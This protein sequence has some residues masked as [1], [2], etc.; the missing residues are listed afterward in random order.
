ML[1]CEARRGVCRMCYGR[2]LATMDMVDM[3]EAVGI[4]AAQSIGEPGTQLT[5]RTFHI[6]GTSSRIA[7]EAERRARSDG[8]V[9]YTDG[10][11]WADV[12]VEYEDGTTDHPAVVLT[13]EDESASDES[14][15]GILV[16]D[17]KDPKRVLNRYPVPEGALLAVKEGDLVTKGDN[18]RRATILYTWDPYNDP[19]IIK[20]DG[21]LRWKDLVPGVTLR[22]E[23]DEGTGLRSIVVMADPDRE[24]HPSVLVYMPNRKDPQEY[25]LAGG[26]PRHPGLAH[27]PGEPGDGDPGR[28]QPVEHQVPRGRAADQRGVAQQDQEGEQG[29]D[30]LPLPAGQGGQGHHGHQ[31]P[32][33]GVQDPRHHGRPPAHR[34]AVRG[35]A[36]EGSGDHLRGG[37][38]GQVRRDQ[39]RQARDLRLPRDPAGQAEEGGSRS[40]TRC[41]PASTS[42]CTRATGCGRATAS[43]RAR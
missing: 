10:L 2:N 5:L 32:A 22:E 16:V 8:K 21:E 35:A 15:E 25:T 42:G 43:P 7:E 36:A 40:C 1:T 17:P 34:G 26:Q 39:A 9:K 18:E 12:P 23:L 27:R 31:D 13:R 38:R 4:L 11:E 20:A 14:K 29:Q 33:A 24:L 28:G 37:R 19:S 30:G 6:G 3:G 41:R